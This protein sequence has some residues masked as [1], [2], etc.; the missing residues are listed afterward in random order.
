MPG[1]IP[2]ASSGAIII[3]DSEGN[4]LN[5]PNIINAY[6]P[7]PEFTTTCE[8][9]ALPDDCTGRIMP[10]QIN[11]IVSELL[12]LAVALTPE[13]EW[14][15]AIPCNLSNA[16]ASWVADTLPG[17]ISDEVNIHDIL[18]NLTPVGGISPSARI[19]ACVDG[20]MVAVQAGTIANLFNPCQVATDIAGCIISADDGNQLETGTDGLLR[21]PPQQP[22]VMQGLDTFTISTTVD[23]SGVIGDPFA[24]YA[25]V[26]ISD[27]P[28]NALTALG[29]GLFVP[30]PPA[31]AYD[32]VSRQKII[33]KRWQSADAAEDNAWIGLDYSPEQN[34]YVAVSSD[35]TNRVMVSNDGRNWTP[36]AAPTQV[37][38][39]VRWVKE[40]GRWIV[41]GHGTSG[42]M[43]SADGLAWNVV[44][45]PDGEWVNFAYSPKL[46]LLV[47]NNRGN[48]STVANAGQ[49]MISS[50]GGETW[51]LNPLPVNN[52]WLGTGW[53]DDLEIF[54]IIGSP[55][56][57][58]SNVTPYVL[59]SI[60]GINWAQH[61][62]PQLSHWWNVIWVTELQ[63]FVAVAN[64]YDLLNAVMTSPDGET[65]T[66]HA[67][68]SAANWYDIA[69][70]PELG[71]LVGV[72][73]NGT[74]RVM[75][76]TDGQ[77]WNLWNPQDGVITG[78]Q[79]WRKVVWSKGQRQ[80]VAVGTSGVDN[81]VM[82][83]TPVIPMSGR[84]TPTLIATTN[85][86]ASMP[87]ECLWSCVDGMMTVSG[88]VRVTPTAGAIATVLSI[89]LPM[90]T[91]IVT[92]V[93]C[94]GSAGANSPIPG[95]PG[96]MSGDSVNDAAF[97]RFVAIDTSE[98]TFGFSLQYE[99]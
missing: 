13:G 30:K 70:S 16:F 39:T 59:T 11:G 9:R 27:N 43:W 8:L 51:V 92:A 78:P 50:D 57:D 58:G 53:S 15:C 54:V 88:T 89:S 66:V 99:L 80:F 82:H 83:T 47:A 85:V 63:L 61:M 55:L 17:I 36:V 31:A 7:P 21:V 44:P 65:W 45:T 71:M 14:D 40:L 26:I 33:A 48:P 64:N 35:G 52:D 29:N 87:F 25:D 95:T 3:R 79:A 86:A 77:A 10:S 20:E 22:V 91:D 1:A 73:N 2:N 19:P 62:L 28:D 42:A 76:S 75:W 68:P 24:V 4:C 94:Q 84:Y 60:D 96:R 98:H 93:D 74:G 23:G 18:C 67:T 6:C 12:C 81:R 46:N 5:P 38:R 32:V 90:A 56:I 49:S 34:L 97:L 72:A 37:W 41:T 69:W